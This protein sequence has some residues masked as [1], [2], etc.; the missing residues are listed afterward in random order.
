[1]LVGFR[2][3]EVCFLFFR[4]GH[5]ILLLVFVAERCG[6][7]FLSI[8]ESEMLVG[9]R[10]GEVWFCFLRCG[11]LK[12]WL[13]FVAGGFGVAFFRCGDL[14]CWQVFVVERCGFVV[15]CGV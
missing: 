13:V 12:C 8:W 1:M 15:R 7:N 4:C 5:L 6:F 3:G 2:Y 11:Y 9:C 10:C 14:R